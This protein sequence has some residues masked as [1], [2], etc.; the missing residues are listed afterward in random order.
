MFQRLVSL[1]EAHQSDCLITQSGCCFVVSVRLR[2]RYEDWS[3]SLC[4]ANYQDSESYLCH[5][6]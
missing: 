3:Q 4:H 5:L 1:E 2:E 6:L